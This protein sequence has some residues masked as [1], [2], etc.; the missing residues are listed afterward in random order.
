MHNPIT[1]ENIIYS[2]I[3]KI[4]DKEAADRWLYNRKQWL[5]IHP[6]EINLDSISYPI[7]LSFSWRNTPEGHEYWKNICILYN[8]LYENKHYI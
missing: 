6:L 3:I 7:K 5:R 4:A 8:K 2:N 1:S